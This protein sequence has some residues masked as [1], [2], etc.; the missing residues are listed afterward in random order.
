MPRFLILCLAL[1][2]AAAV[3]SPAPVVPFSSGAACAGVATSTVCLLPAPVNVKRKI[4]LVLLN[5]QSAGTST[6]SLVSSPSSTN[7]SVSPTTLI[8]TL[9]LSSGG[10]G[11]ISF[12]PPLPIRPGHVICCIP[13][14][15]S[16]C[17][18]WGIDE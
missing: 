18:V 1:L 8:P 17:S 5:T 7:C 4:T 2:A 3:A 9:I 14:A 12:N 13:S 11:P 10:G 15:T 6:V 16:T